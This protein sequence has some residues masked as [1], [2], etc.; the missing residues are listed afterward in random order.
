MVE[1]GAAVPL[2]LLAE[3]LSD[4]P[5]GAADG[6]NVS[7]GQPAVEFAA[8]SQNGLRQKMMRG[9]GRLVFRP[10]FRKG[11][12]RTKIDG[13]VNE[14]DRVALGAVQ[15]V[16]DSELVIGVADDPGKILFPQALDKDRPGA[17]VAAAGVADAD[18][19]GF[20]VAQRLFLSMTRPAASWNSI[21]R[22]ILPR[23][24]VAQL[25][26]GS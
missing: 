15:G 18:D 24:W 4:V 9:H 23:A 6:Q 22:G 26:H 1:G 16:L 14:D 20:T 21:S 7:P 11:E 2:G 12:R 3:P 13:G 10:D 5:V 17:V 25:R 8:E 19:Q